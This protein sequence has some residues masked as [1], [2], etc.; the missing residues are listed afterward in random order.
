MSAREELVALSGE[1]DGGTIPLLAEESTD[2]VPIV[3]LESTGLAEL[4]ELL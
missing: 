4:E 2:P 1:A 3:P